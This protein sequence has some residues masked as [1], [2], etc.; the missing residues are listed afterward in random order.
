MTGWQSYF[1]R[2]AETH[3][4]NTDLEIFA[5]KGNSGAPLRSTTVEVGYGSAV[6]PGRQP[7]EKTVDGS[8]HSLPT[9][10]WPVVT[11]CTCPVPSP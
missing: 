4:I 7:K 5:V 9:V 3:V 2:K 8:S 10:D 6:Q 11:D 1:P